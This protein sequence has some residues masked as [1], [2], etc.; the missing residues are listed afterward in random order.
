MEIIQFEDKGLAHFSYAV[1]SEGEMALVDPERNPQQYYDLAE[2]HGA[3]IKIV[4]ETHP[5]ADFVSSH[6][7]IRETTGAEIWVSEKLGAEYPH[8]AFDDGDTVSLGKITFRALNTPGHSPDSISI[9][10]IDENGK[11]TAVFTGDTLFIGDCGRPDLRE[12]AGAIKAQREDLARQM[13]HSLRDK[14]AVLP[15][16]VVVYPAHGAGS[17]CGK[18]LSASNSSTI[19]AEKA[20]NWCMQNL[21]EEEFVHELLKDQPF[22][23]KY[24]TNSVEMNK[25]GA[26]PYAHYTGILEVVEGLPSSFGEGVII[27]ARHEASF[28]SGHIPGSIN[29]MNGAKFETWLGSIVAPGEPFYLI[30]SSKQELTALI[31]KAARIG[32]EAQIQGV[33][34]VDE[35]DGAKLPATDVHAFREN[36]QG[37]TIV[38]IRNTGEVKSKPVFANALHIPLYELRERAHEIP[39]EKP[40]MVHCAAGYR[41]AAGAS[42]IRK[43]LPPTVDVFDLGEAIRQF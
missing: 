35:I 18:G 29:L 3:K 1:V 23:P 42:I 6:D 33:Y 43:N 5:H 34:K 41:S 32:Y 38:D 20:T 37:Y 36:L 9:V 25:K 13:Y 40:V 8:K 11:E 26:P 10:L 7:E 22:V 19:G 24:F 15:D 16:D 28:K 27:D 30:G 14:L 12:A 2:Q 39:A 31:D 4:F 17:L 21:T